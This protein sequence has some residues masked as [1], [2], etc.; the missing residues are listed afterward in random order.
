MKTVQ[1]KEEYLSITD[2]ARLRNVTT[3]TLRHYDRIG[4][5]QPDYVNEQHIR[6]YSVLKYEKLETIRELKQLG[7]SL[8]EIKAYFEKR[9]Y[10]SSKKLLETQDRLLQKQIHDLMCIREKVWKKRQF[11]NDLEAEH[12]SK[13]PYVRYFQKR[14]Y[15][16]SEHR[17][18]N[19]VE[20][21]YEAMQ[22]ERRIYE[23]EAYLPIYATARYGGIFPINEQNRRDIHVLMFYEDI[24]E[25]TDA[26]VLPEGYY[27]C[28]RMRGSFWKRRESLRQLHQILEE[29]QYQIIQPVIIENV[30]IDYTITDVEKERLFEFQIP[31]T[32][33]DLV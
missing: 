15:L 2:M 18:E 17:V 8:N 19:E 14:S 5:L 6:Y 11:L 26:H 4:L 27:L 21:A 29:R 24:S 32:G 20:L 1:R 22:L 23:T 10:E 9:D 33:S 12:V 16:L 31:V 30:L 25:D 13:E 28:L 7:M 3:E